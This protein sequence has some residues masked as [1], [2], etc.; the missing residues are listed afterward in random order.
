MLRRYGGGFE[1]FLDLP[2]AMG[3]K[4]ITKAIEDEKDDD[5]RAEW[6]ALLPWMQSG[7]LKLIQW[8]E[9]REQRLGLNI[10]R[11]PTDEIIRELEND[12]NTRLV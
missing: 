1:A 3:A 7:Q 6:V 9:Y 11:R 5:L 2:A 10:D 12:F 4:L 8:Q